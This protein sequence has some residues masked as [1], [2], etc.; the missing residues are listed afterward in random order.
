MTK[1]KKGTSNR[2]WRGKPQRSRSIS[3]ENASS[4]NENQKRTTSKVIA[5]DL[6]FRERDTFLDWGKTKTQ[7]IGDLKSRGEF[8]ST[9]NPCR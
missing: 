4:G 1:S 3:W 5:R 6:N 9:I 8:Q 7:C 2:S